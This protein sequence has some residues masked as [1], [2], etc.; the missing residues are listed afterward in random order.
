MARKK[1]KP[2]MNPEDYKI[3]PLIQ[4]NFKVKVNKML[5]KHQFKVNTDNV[6]GKD[7]LLP[8]EIEL[9]AEPYVKLFPLASARK[10]L[11][12]LSPSAIKL[13]LFIAFEL[14]PARDY[15]W[16]NKARFMKESNIINR[17]TFNNAISE[18]IKETVICPSFEPDV[19]WINPRLFFNGSRINK[20][21]N[22]L[23]FN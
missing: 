14:E 16:I 12:T 22:N 13:F 19:Y 18:L 7:M 21:K 1:I 23:E 11:Q 17:Q 9:E 6:D 15:I 20:Y 5:L 4:N 3:N 8:A 10:I 2:D